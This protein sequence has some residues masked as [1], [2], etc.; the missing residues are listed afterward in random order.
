MADILRRRKADA[1]GRR[2]FPDPVPI[3]PS[4]ACHH[5]NTLLQRAGLPNIHI[6]D[7][8]HTFAIHALTSGV[9]A[10]TLSGMPGHHSA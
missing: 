7:L 4:A 5:M 1:I 9:G 2:I 10:K 3:D 8:R 6:H